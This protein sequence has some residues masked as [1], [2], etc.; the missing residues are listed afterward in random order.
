MDLGCTCKVGFEELAAIPRYWLFKWGWRL[1]YDIWPE[2]L[3]ILET[4]FPLR[5][6]EGNMKENPPKEEDTYHRLNYAIL[7]V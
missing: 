1:T 2:Y 4:S 3:R 7:S 5:K 6:E